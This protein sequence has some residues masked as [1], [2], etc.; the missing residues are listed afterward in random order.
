MA[1]GTTLVLLPRA[2]GIWIGPAATGGPAKLMVRA[3]GARDL[4]IGLGTMNA[5]REGAPAKGWALAGT[6]SDLLDAAAT[7]LAIR[8]LG[9]RR[10]L[11]VIAVATAAGIAG[12]VAAEHLD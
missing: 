10:A 2:A 11:P 9:L 12:Y 7:L 5:L 4:A 6:A 8:H 1:V 3:T